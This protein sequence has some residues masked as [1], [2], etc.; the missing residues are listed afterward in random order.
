MTQQHLNFG[1]Q[2]D[3][4]AHGGTPGDTL[5]AAMLK[6]EANFNDL[7][8]ST[9]VGGIGQGVNA[10]SAAFTGTTVQKVNAAAALALTNGL[11]YVVVPLAFLPY[12]DSQLVV[13]ASITLVPE[14][15][16]YVPGVRDARAY[17]GLINAWRAIGK[18]AATLPATGGVVDCRGFSGNQVADNDC[19]LNVLAEKPI[20]FLFGPSVWSCQQANS[21]MIMSLFGSNIEVHGDETVFKLNDGQNQ[22]YMFYSDISAG[23]A[24]A[25]V[26]N[27]SATVTLPVPSRGVIPKVNKAISI[28]GHVPSGGQRDN[29]TLNGAIDN[30]QTSGIVLTSTTGQIAVGPAYIKVDNE[31]IGYTSF[32]GST[33]V[34]VTRGAKGS[35]AASHLNLAA[36]DRVVYDN[37]F[38]L[39]VTGAG[40]YTL[41]LDRL[42][43]CVT[44][45][46]VDSVIG[47]ADCSFTGTITFDGNKPAVDTSANGGAIQIFH[48]CRLKVERTCV[49][50]NFDHFG[51]FTVQHPFAVVDGTFQNLGWPT[52]TGIGFSV[53]FFQGSKYCTAYGDYFNVNAGPVCDDRTNAA[54]V[55]DNSP[56]G[57]IMLPRS[58][59]Y[60]KQGI[61][62]EGTSQSFAYAPRIENWGFGVAGYPA[63]LN[64]PQWVTNGTPTNCTI[65]LGVV[66]PATSGSVSLAT[67]STKNFIAC[68]TPGVTVVDNGTANV[69]WTIDGASV[70]HINTKF[71]FDNGFTG[72][73]TFASADAGQDNPFLL[74]GIWSI[75]D[76]GFKVGLQAQAKAT[77]TSGSQGTLI[78]VRPVAWAAGVGGVTIAAYSV[79][80]DG[81]VD[82]T[83]TT[84]S[85]VYINPPA[86]A[87]AI[88]NLYGVNIP[89]F[90]RGTTL[91]IGLNIGSITGTG[92]KALQTAN[93]QVSFGD[94]VLV[95]STVGGATNSQ[96]QSLSPDATVQTN[97]ITFNA[98]SAATPGRIGCVTNHAFGFVTNNI[99]RGQWDTSGNLVMDTTNGGTVQ[100]RV[101][102]AAAVAKHVRILFQAA[103]LNTTSTSDASI[104]SFSLPANALAVNAQAVRIIARGREVTQAGAFNIKFGATIVATISPAAAA[105]W[106]IEII[107]TRTGATAQLSIGR[108]G[109]SGVFAAVSSQPVETLSGAVLID[110]RGSVTS[111]GTLD[112]DYAQVEY[113][114][115]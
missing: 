28:F 17:G 91:N 20:K 54:Q 38:I 100:D 59:K 41:T 68:Y 44:M 6:V 106:E 98:G 48:G 1:S 21:A 58:I 5:D 111:G 85:G 53:L 76:S 35:T 103:G 64:S 46:A 27:G 105:N 57:C 47:P 112:L 45:T 30:V 18:A 25:S 102:S 19:L 108:T 77:H 104:T 88:T 16:D 15:A 63:G 71:Q 67:G 36:V 113:L 37:Y 66:L 101:G 49:F 10:G 29:T 32:S 55:Y 8:V 86:G 115:S 2:P 80:V 95:Q 31:I 99:L 74:T 40:P 107:V 90:S 87:G 22:S 26:T 11:K 84:Y 61:T 93:G 97:Y 52:T 96:Y 110:F 50:Q 34:G 72:N 14:A 65:I 62:L 83:V 43:T 23:F 73:Q 109:V 60:V 24:F 114:A 33:L 94:T 81:Q 75:A 39:A 89:A 92:A 9:G 4:L 51:V 56:I 69:I 7:Y 12:D 82:G 13:D 42:V 79:Y 78:G 3:A 70:Q